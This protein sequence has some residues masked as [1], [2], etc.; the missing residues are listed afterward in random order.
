MSGRLH[1]FTRLLCSLSGKVLAGH[2]GHNSITCNNKNNYKAT[3]MLSGG[4]S[5]SLEEGASLG[6]RAVVRGVAIRQ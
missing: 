3:L 5:S 4:D 1:T 6:V 2:I